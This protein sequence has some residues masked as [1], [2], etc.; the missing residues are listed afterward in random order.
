[1]GNA[2][3]AIVLLQVD[4]ARSRRQGWQGYFAARQ[5]TPYTSDVCDLPG[6]L[7]VA[8]GLSSSRLQIWEPGTQRDQTRSSLWILS[9][10]SLAAHV[11]LF[12]VSVKVNPN[13][14]SSVSESSPFWGC[15]NLKSC[16]LLLLS[17]VLCL[18][19][20]SRGDFKLFHK[21]MASIDWRCLSRDAWPC[22][23]HV[24]ETG[25]LTLRHLRWRWCQINIS[26]GGYVMNV[27]FISCHMA[28]H[29]ALRA[30]ENIASC[31][32]LWLC[33][34]GSAWQSLSETQVAWQI[35]C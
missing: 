18:N 19:E 21:L 17:S 23:T 9:L 34:T 35:N 12:V 31:N 30:I 10:S 8:G 3:F 28:D 14:E 27:S 22:R 24:T 6:D 16:K 20:I 5:R 25:L 32:A 7:W 4:P 2:E 33:E 13:I 11:S 15:R 29:K 1:M 26:A